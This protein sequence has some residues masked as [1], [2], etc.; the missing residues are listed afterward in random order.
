MSSDDELV[1]GGQ[2]RSESNMSE[3]VIGVS[4]CLIGAFIIAVVAICFL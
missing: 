1:R 4:M 2:G 3:S